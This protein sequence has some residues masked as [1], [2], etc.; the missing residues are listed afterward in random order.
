MKNDD[1]RLKNIIVEEISKEVKESMT[2]L[3]KML[4]ID[5]NTK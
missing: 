5:F 2:L 4:L 1:I 3:D